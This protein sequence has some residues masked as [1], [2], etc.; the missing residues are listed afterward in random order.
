[1]AARLGIA[2]IRPMILKIHQLSDLYP[3]DDSYFDVQRRPAHSHGRTPSEDYSSQVASIGARSKRFRGRQEELARLRSKIS[4]LL[5]A[6]SRFSECRL[7][8]VYTWI[9]FIRSMIWYIA[10]FCSR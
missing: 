10:I 1:M 4:L 7:I 6:Y 8:I 2:T 5:L 9:V 3:G